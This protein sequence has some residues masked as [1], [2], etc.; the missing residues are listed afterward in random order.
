MLYEAYGKK[1]SYQYKSETGYPDFLYKADNYSAILDTKYIP[2]YEEKKLD[3]Y[4]IRQL[5]G[6]A[7]DLKILKRLGVEGLDGEPENVKQ[8]PC[9][10]IYPDEKVAVADPFRNTDM[11]DV[12]K[13]KE[14]NI[15]QFYKIAVSL[16]AIGG[17]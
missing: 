17:K 9:I 11:K 1:V 12:R 3:T 4:V 13:V 7:R 8:V 16:P 5:S 10:I 14:P 2:K 6:Y 15:L